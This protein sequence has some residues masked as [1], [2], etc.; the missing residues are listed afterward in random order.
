MVAEL[1]DC[2]DKRWSLQRI[3][4][5]AILALFMVGGWA[6]AANAA[7]TIQF[8]NEANPGA[9]ADAA[10][11]TKDAQAIGVAN[12]HIVQLLNQKKYAEAIP[13]LCK[14]AVTNGDAWAGL[15]LGNLYTAGFG[16]PR[17]E[18][19]A[20]HWYLWSAEQGDRAAQRKV[21]NAYL[22]GV[23]VKANAQKAAYW[24]TI[25]M[26][27]P[28]VVNSDYWLGKTYAG[29]HLVPA[30]ASKASYYLQRSQTLLQRLAREPDNGA[31]AYE[32]GISYLYGNGVPKNREEARYWLERAIAL[33]YGK[34]AVVLHHMEDTHS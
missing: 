31:A 27:V 15:T 25:G 20:F 5:T 34:A 28:Q 33:H 4:I 6:T 19:E 3:G 12:H 23:G 2:P 17:S 1:W 22:N 32:M 26:A 14:A 10:R 13:M 24:F 21:A 29:G 30:N 16:V 7:T 18:R 8:S 9:G 11:Y